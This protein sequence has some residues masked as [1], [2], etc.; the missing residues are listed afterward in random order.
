MNSLPRNIHQV[1]LGDKAPPGNT[2]PDSFKKHHP[3]WCYTRWNDEGLGDFDI[4]DDLDPQIRAL[5][6]GLWPLCRTTAQAS[7]ILRLAI[8]WSYGG[9]YADI[10]CAAL[11]PLDPLFEGKPGDS[12]FLTWDVMGL[13]FNNCFMAGPAHDPFWI[14][15]L[16]EA[17]KRM[18]SEVRQPPFRETGPF[19]VTTIANLSDYSKRVVALDSTILTP[20]PTHSPAR[21]KAYLYHA[22][23][24]SWV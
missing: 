15:C 7:D 2:D 5:T 1:W 9:V 22:G 23:D 20:L 11:K 21:R 24:K 6:R 10:D 17:R 12:V 13:V 14:D 16:A 4:V 18:S 19:L 8:L 3:L